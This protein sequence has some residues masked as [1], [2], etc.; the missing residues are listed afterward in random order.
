MRQLGTR[1]LLALLLIGLVTTGAALGEQVVVKRNVNLRHDPSTSQ[2]PIRLL[3]PPETL[4]LVVPEKTNEYYH[5]KSTQGED[6]W[7]WSRNVAVVEGT[8]SP[9][10]I[11]SATVEDGWGTSAPSENTF[12]RT[13]T[14][15]TCGPFGDDPGNQTNLRKN[16]TD[17]P[18]SYH[19]VTFDAIGH[20]AFPVEKKQRADWSAQHLDEIARF[21][22]APVTLVGYIVNRIKVQSGGS[23]E[24]T[25]CHWTTSDVVDWH[26][27]LVEHPGDPES[28]AVVVETTPR[29]RVSHAKWTPG[30]LEPWVNSQLPVRISGWLMLD[31]EH[32]NHL[33]KYRETLWEV[34]PITDIAV[35][36]NGQWVD[37]NDMP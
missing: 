19:L 5:V 31:P 13:D 3:K 16:R 8:A 32:R 36:Y 30:R 28:T 18:G 14:G 29:V 11:P 6:G 4:D 15:A 22:G 27:P 2:A 23:G 26:V 21:E 17:V 1:R 12:T 34:H 35:F 7:V 24:S 9:E 20:L 33:G 10:E 25:N 37:L